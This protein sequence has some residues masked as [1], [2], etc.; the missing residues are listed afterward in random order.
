MYR[1][2]ESFTTKNYDVRRKQI[3]ADDFT[4]EDEI[5]EF[6][7]I[8]YIEVYDGTLE[9]TENGTYDVSDYES[10][11]VDVSG[12]GGYNALIDG[13][14]TYDQVYGIRSLMTNVDMN[15]IKLTNLRACFTGM[16]ALES[17]TN[18]DT[19]DTISMNYT[20][21]NCSNLLS[22]P[23][24]D[25]AKV[26]DFRGCFYNCSSLVDFPIITMDLSTATNCNQMFFGCTSL[27]NE[28]LNN[29]M[30]SLLI[31]PVRN[32]TLKNLGL[33]QT[34]AETCTTLS[35]WSALNAA[36]WSTGY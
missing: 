23:Q 1:A 28:S 36:G 6:L 10:A 13:T 8:G 33:T 27:S 12:G 32:G 14:K 18:L 2:L 34:Q 4:N 11:E 21:E 30:A 15:G 29:I 5:N 25:T 9:I 26:T 24:I 20:F 22:I 16:T 7:D 19:S 31:R 17:V 35:N 3:L